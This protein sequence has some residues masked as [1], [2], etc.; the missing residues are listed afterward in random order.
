MKAQKRAVLS[1]IDSFESLQRGI[2]QARI[3]AK[4]VQEM[5]AELDDSRV[6]LAKPSLVEF[7][8]SV[9]NA[10]TA[11]NMR[12]QDQHVGTTTERAVAAIEVLGAKEAEIDRPERDALLED[13]AILDWLEK[14]VV[15][16]RVD[17]VLGSRHL[18]YATPPDWD[19]SDGPSSIRAQSIEA[20][21]KDAASYAAALSLR[22]QAERLSSDHA[23]N[24]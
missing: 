1:A 20:M 22:S 14:Q 6:A 7:F 16:V 10:L 9:C 2:P 11:R 4:L 3:A 24:N 5:R 8:A 23:V 15:E 18:F 12:W 19:G 17:L 13:M 21:T